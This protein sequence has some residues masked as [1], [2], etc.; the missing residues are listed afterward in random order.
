MDN[1]WHVELKWY[2]IPIFAG[3]LED[4]DPENIIHVDLNSLMHS[5]ARIMKEWHKKVNNNLSAERYK[6]IEQNLYQAIDK[7]RIIESLGLI[8]YVRH[9]HILIRSDAAFKY[10]NNH[11]DG[12]LYRSIGTEVE[13][14]C[15]EISAHNQHSSFDDFFEYVIE[16]T[17]LDH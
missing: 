6:I 13:V 5:N 16:I 17:G 11:L 3:S 14:W 15:T 10:V 4:A 8:S 9:Y 2:N 7:V 12:I 1:V